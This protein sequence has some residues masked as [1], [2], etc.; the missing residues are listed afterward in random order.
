MKGMRSS[1]LGLVLLLAGCASST[2]EAPGS[3]GLLEGSLEEPEGVVLKVSYYRAYAEPRTKRLEP[4]YKVVMSEGWREKMG[5]SPRDPLVKAA[6][7]K[8]FIGF[9]GDASLRKYVGILKDMGIERL[10]PRDTD[11]LPPPAELQ[12]QAL[13]PQ[14]TEYTRIITIADEKGSRSYS[15]PDQQVS[16]EMIKTFL[17]CERFVLRIVEHSIHITVGA[18]HRVFPTDR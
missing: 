18:T 12:R 17:D 11:S 7:G 5:E 2:G 4:T 16:A 8:L 3:S 1:S 15:Y 9:L 13:N 14:R 6:P 10:V